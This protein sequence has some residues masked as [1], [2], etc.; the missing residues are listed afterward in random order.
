MIELGKT[1]VFQNDNVLEIPLILTDEEIN[2]ICYNKGI[3][4]KEDFLTAEEKRG[5]CYPQ[6]NL[7]EAYRNVVNQGYPVLRITK[8]F[9]RSMGEISE[10]GGYH[11]KTIL[12]SE[13]SQWAVKKLKTSIDSIK[14]QKPIVSEF[15]LNLRKVG[16]LEEDYDCYPPLYTVSRMKLSDIVDMYFREKVG[17]LTEQ[18]KSMFSLYRNFDLESLLFNE[19]IEQLSI[20]NRNCGVIIVGSHEIKALP[21]TK[22]CHQE[23]VQNLLVA[24][25]EEV[26]LGN[27]TS[28]MESVHT[29]QSAIGIIT[30]GYIAFYLPEAIN[31]FQKERLFEIDDELNLLACNHE[32]MVNSSSVSNDLQLHD[33]NL[34]FGILIDKCY[35]NYEC[36]SK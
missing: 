19:E 16:E 27:K 17:R 22:L 35:N 8:E 3:V 13:T 11:L 26:N 36:K 31:S 9:M 21:V 10:T 28:I 25:G 12:P 15:V 29:Y 23:T 33:D 32:L 24:M 5:Y 18:E 34:S 2:E 6:L 20:S 4:K 30:P 14:E 7:R 1:F